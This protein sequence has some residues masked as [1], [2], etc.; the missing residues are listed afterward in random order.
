MDAWPLVGAAVLI[1]ACFT[2]VVATHFTFKLFLIVLVCKKALHL[3]ANMQGTSP[4]VRL[5]A[6][7]LVPVL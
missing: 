4:R 1:T 3:V 6:I 7:L 5:F 2:R